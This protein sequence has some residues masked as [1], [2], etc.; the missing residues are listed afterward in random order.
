MSTKTTANAL[1]DSMFSDTRSIPIKVNGH[2]L[3]VTYNRPFFSI[4]AMLERSRIEN[5]AKERL[6][7]DSPEFIEHNLAAVRDYLVEMLVDWDLPGPDGNGVPINAET[8][9]QLSA[10]V[11]QQLWEQVGNDASPKSP[12]R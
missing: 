6:G 3:R 9:G 1:Y 5:E 10:G 4:D 11:I 7:E 2:K 8:I 12:N